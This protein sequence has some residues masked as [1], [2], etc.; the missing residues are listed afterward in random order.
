M[1]ELTS[2]SQ[3]VMLGIKNKA[4]LAHTIENLPEA[5][6]DIILVVGYKKEQIINYFGNEYQGLKISYVEQKKLN[7]TGGAILLVKDI[8]GDE[9][10]LVLFG[11]DLYQKADLEKMLAYDYAVLAFQTNQAE[12]FGL[13]TEDENGFV[14]SIV[15]KPHG[16]QTGLVDVG[17]FV[18]SKEYFGYPPVYWCEQESSLPTTLASMYPKYKAK[19][20]KTK[21]WCPIGIPDDLLKAEK[22]IAKF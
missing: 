12:R 7:G 1:G 15:E 8:I 5:I 6:T 17:V 3:K 20:I 14:S 2:D 19:I 9:K 16:H 10:I 22:D 4:K 21:H 11:D 18:L 13:I